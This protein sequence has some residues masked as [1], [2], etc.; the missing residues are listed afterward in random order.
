MMICSKDVSS[1]PLLDVFGPSGVASVLASGAL[2]C[3]CVSE[4]ITWTRV[5]S[6]LLFAPLQQ[7]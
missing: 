1:P 4:V 6:V 5:S 2:D 7:R 3:E